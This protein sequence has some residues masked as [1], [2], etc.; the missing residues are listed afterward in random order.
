MSRVRRRIDA[1]CIAAS[2]LLH[3][4]VLF[5]VLMYLPRAEPIPEKQV[6]SIELLKESG[7]EG[8]KAGGEAAGAEQASATPEEAT[9]APVA[10]PTPPKPKPKPVAK[11]KAAPTPAPVP[12][13]AVAEAPIVP[14]PPPPMPTPLPEPVVIAQPYPTTPSGGASAGA[15]GG[16]GVG[17][18]AGQ[19]SQGAGAGAY[20]DGQGPGDDYLNRV[21][22]WIAKHKKYPPEAFKRKQEGSVMVAFTIARDG[23]ILGAEI[24]RSSG[25]PLIDQATLD[26]L[27]RASPVPPVPP[28]YTGERLSI[29]IPVRFSIALLDKLF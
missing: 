28:H 12:P 8:A 2:L 15:A 23:R 29:A 19:G 16:T 14:L 22:R 10:K 17:V 27:Y 18:G 7:A 4:A 11:P 26:M 6:V 1:R 9:P 20:G 3:L 24:E 13:V 21:R 5:G 25:F